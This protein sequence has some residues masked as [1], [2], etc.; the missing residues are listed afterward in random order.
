MGGSLDVRL[1]LRPGHLAMPPSPMHCL[2]RPGSARHAQ[3]AYPTTGRA[4]ET[5]C[6]GWR[7]HASMLLSTATPL[8]TRGSAR[9]A[10]RPDSVVAK[11]IDRL[12]PSPRAWGGDQLFRLPD[13]EVVTSESDTSGI[14]LQL[15]LQPGQVNCPVS[16]KQ[17]FDARGKEKPHSIHI[18]RDLSFIAIDIGRTSFPIQRG[19][20]YVCI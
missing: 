18:D 11:C 8:A 12:S 13:I 2:A 6:G 14:Q 10:H 20:I 16:I 7:R 19:D 4:H 5:P 1:S 15:Q 9:P 17:G 3:Q